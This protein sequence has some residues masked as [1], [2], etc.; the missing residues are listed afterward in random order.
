MHPFGIERRR[1]E[2]IRR[3][4]GAADRLEAVADDS[5][6]LGARLRAIA[7]IG[8][9]TE[10]TV[11]QAVTG[12]ADAV[13]LGDYHFPSL[14]AWNLERETRADDTRMLALLDPFAGHRARVL[15]LIV[16][17][18]DKPPRR[19]PKRQLRSIARI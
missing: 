12:D 13:P 2:T 6:A 10:A 15:R 16:R 19:G 8:P 4:A 5:E 7:G 1:A 14:V 11:R 17:A 3:A 9:W 18:G